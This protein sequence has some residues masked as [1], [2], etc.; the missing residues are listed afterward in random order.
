MGRRRA[1]KRSLNENPGRET[2]SRTSRSRNTP[3]SSANVN[4]NG[5]GQVDHVNAAENQ[6]IA[7]NNAA[8]NAPNNVPE[9]G[10]SA[11]P[12]A[13]APVAAAASS[14]GGIREQAASLVHGVPGE[15]ASGGSSVSGTVASSV[16]SV[17]TCLSGGLFSHANLMPMATSMSASSNMVNVPN[18]S[19]LSTATGLPAGFIAPGN[20]MHMPTN[21]TGTSTTNTTLGGSIMGTGVTNIA[22]NP[23]TSVCSPL[24]V[25]LPQAMRAK[26]VNSEF[27]DFGQLLEKSEHL[28][29]DDTQY[30]LAVGQGGT[31]VWQESK[32]KRNINSVHTWTSA[33]LIFSAVYLS[34]HPHRVQEMLKYAQVIR[35]AAARHEGWGWRSYD[36]QFRLRQEWQPQRSW[37]II[38]G[39]L[40][41]LFVVSSVA[42]P[43]Q[44]KQVQSGGTL[45]Q[46]EN[47]GFRFRSQQ[48]ATQ[49]KVQGISSGDPSWKATA[50]AGKLCFDF[51]GAGCTRPKCKFNHKCA[52]C[53]AIGHGAQKCGKSGK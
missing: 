12:V 24:G 40:W 37:A 48:S 3:G 52:Q 49:K 35:T 53:S 34:A 22:R 50:V 13:P 17:S 41:S 9:A 2:R 11:Q 36:I 4:S 46:Q 38:D 43:I 26:I 19:S 10:S 42:R 18:V 5:G 15:L 51:N 31:L 32:S 27:V 47:K 16:S 14:S 33:F 44:M 7:P 30:S 23:L 28:G 1:T 8:N 20:L 21:T 29:K 39:E 45:P 25:Q 6:D